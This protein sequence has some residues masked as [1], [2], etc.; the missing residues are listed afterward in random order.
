M[1]MLDDDTATYVLALAEAID[2][3]LKIEDEAQFNELA[4]L[5]L[6][7]VKEFMWHLLLPNGASHLVDDKGGSV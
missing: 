4:N 6:W 7:K 1:A 3:T 5:V 2:R